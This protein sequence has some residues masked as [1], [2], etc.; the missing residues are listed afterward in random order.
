MEVMTQYTPCFMVEK[1]GIFHGYILNWDC[2]G[3]KAL[4]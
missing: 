4:L 1:T 3:F 2:H